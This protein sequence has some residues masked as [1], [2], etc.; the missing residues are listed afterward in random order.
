VSELESTASGAVGCTILAAGAGRRFGGPKP[1]ASLAGEPLVR[2]AVTAAC[3]S[4]AGRVAVIT[5]AHDLG[6]A[7]E[8][9]PV[10]RVDNPDWASGVASSIRCAVGW[11]RRHQ[12]D[13]LLIATVDQPH[14]DAR[15]LDRLLEA[16]DRGRCLTASAYSA[17]L[18]V[19]ALFPRRFFPALARLTG[20][21]GARALL[22]DPA[23]GALPVPWPPGAVDVDFAAE[24][25][26]YQDP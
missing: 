17:L 2:R 13:A 10:E 23:N 20:D 22:R 24:L 21:V 8:G 9:L 18:G 16:S 12:L 26:G 3:G 11:A 6:D 15:H 5:G 1:L 25:A 7:L 14:L 4:A 19:P